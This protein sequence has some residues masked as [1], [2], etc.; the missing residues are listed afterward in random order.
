M[1]QKLVLT[2]LILLKTGVCFAQEDGWI[3]F[4]P[5]EL[6]SL[7]NDKKSLIEN[8]GRLTLVY[9]ISGWCDTCSAH[10]QMI[11]YLHQKYASQGLRTILIY[12][13]EP[14]AEAKNHFS[15]ISFSSQAYLGNDEVIENFYNPIVPTIFLIDR[16]GYLTGRYTT[17]SQLND[18]SQLV[19][20]TLSY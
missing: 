6:T 12:I 1:L 5:V 8:A 19:M 16:K 20:L 4:K 7:I 18:L 11:K 10:T 14:L 13:H 2:L 17:Q 15:K 3:K 9:F